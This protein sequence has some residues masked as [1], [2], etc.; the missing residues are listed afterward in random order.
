M[1]LFSK[2]EPKQIKLRTGAQLYCTVCKFELFFERSAPLHS[3]GATLF[4]FAWMSPVCECWVC[5]RCGF[6][7]WFLGEK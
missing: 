5:G 7:H 2:E 4:N 1:G 3:R 6:V